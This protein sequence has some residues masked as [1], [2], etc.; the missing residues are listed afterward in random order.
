L[1]LIP[2]VST[3]YVDPFRTE[4]TLVIIFDIYNPRNGEIYHRDPRQIAKKAEKY[5]A[6]TG[7]A[8]TAFFAS[9]AEFFIFDDVRYEV[10]PNKSY[11]EVDSSEGAWNSGRVEEGGNLGNKT[12]LKGGYF[13]VPPVDQM[14][15]L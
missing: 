4:R 9:E 3:A 7:V 11:Y 10:K 2:D 14:A 6:S 12:P 1:Q 15:D 5:L 13:P 8:D